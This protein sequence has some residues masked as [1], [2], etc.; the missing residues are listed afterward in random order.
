MKV[1]STL[2]GVKI[3]G[4]YSFL[5]PI[6]P[7]VADKAPAYNNG[8]TWLDT[9]TGFSYIL[10][11]QVLGTWEQTE[12]STD[13]KINTI[14][15]NL[16]MSVV[17]Y[18]GNIFAIDRNKNYIGN[19]NDYYDDFPNGLPPLRKIDIIKLLT[20][21][22]V[23]SR[24]KFTAVDTDTFTVE[25]GTDEYLYGS[26]V[27]SFIVG[28]TIYIQGSRRND[29]YYTIVAIN[30]TLNQISVAEP[31]TT[32]TS[33][34]F[35]Y[36]CNVV[37]E[38]IQIVNS[39]IYYDIVSKPRVTGL[40]SESIGTYSWTSKNLDAMNYPADVISRLDNYK[41]IGIGGESIFVN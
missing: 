34:A 28:D 22:S 30:T 18:L 39:M 32:E 9:V 2:S 7:T 36:L 5:K 12:T 29:G 41:M 14:K 4:A 21:E 6:A 23:Y 31:I 1:F 26:I 11:D 19:S 24:W 17:R 10:V 37:E 40:Q 38:F 13:E 27:D 8:D 15:D 33:Y 3:N 16:F 20:L 35:I 25:P